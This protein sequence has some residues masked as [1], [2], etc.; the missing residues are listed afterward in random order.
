MPS[1]ASIA[2]EQELDRLVEELDR[3]EHVVDEAEL[4]GV[5]SPDHPVLLERVVDD[6]LDGG[7]G[8]DET[9]RELRP[10]PGGEQPDEHL[11]EAEVPDVRGHRADVAVQRDLEPA[12]ERGAVD[13]GERRK[14]QLPQPAEELVPRLSALA[15][16]LG[17]DPREL[18]DVR[19]G[20]EDERLA[21]EDETAPVAR[22]ERSSTPESDRSASGPKVFGLRQSAPLS[23][24]TSA[25]GPTRVASRCRWNWVTPSRQ[26]W[27][28][29]SQRSAA[30]M[31]SPMQSAVSP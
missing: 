23:M 4:E 22:T 19:A 9:R 6:Q 31:P 16:A 3:I 18:R 28:G 11:G 5:G 21:G 20:G 30:P 15:G 25:T 14:R 24:V 12:P 29:F 17:R 26:P 1:P 8:A 10:P 13:G 7:L 2:A 27:R